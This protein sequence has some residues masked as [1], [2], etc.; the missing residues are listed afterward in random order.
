MSE[1]PVTSDVPSE[2]APRRGRKRAAFAIA[3]SIALAIAVLAIARSSHPEHRDSAPP[4]AALTVHVLTDGLPLEAAK[5]TAISNDWKHVSETAA[6]GDSEIDGAPSGPLTLTIEAEGFARATRT[7]ELHAGKS[8]VR[9]DLFLGAHLEGRVRDDTERPVPGAIVTVRPLGGGALAQEPPWLAT[10]RPDGSFSIDTLPQTR[11]TIEARGSEEFEPAVIAELELPS[12][13]PVELVLRRTAAITGGVHAA[14]GSGVAGALVTLAGSG[15]WPARTALTGPRGEFRFERVPDGIYELRAERDD[16]VSAP[17]EGIAIGPG[18]EA[19]VEIVLMAGQRLRGLVRDIANGRL[20]PDADIEVSEESLSANPKHVRSGNDGRYVISGLRPLAHR[21][22]VRANG[23]VTAQ[24]WATPNDGVFDLE[25]LRAGSISGTIQDSTGRPIALAEIEVSGRSVT[26]YTVRMLGPLNEV[27]DPS[28]PDS[29]DAAP[30][31]GNLGVT[32]AVPRLPIV[33][34]PSAVRPASGA[35]DGGFRSDARGHFQLDGLPPGE[36]V[37]AARKANFATGRSHPLQLRSGDALHDIVIELPV[38]EPLHGHV[39]DGRGAPV[40]RVRLEL[41]AANEPTRATVSGPDGA[42]RFEG[43]RGESTLVARANGAALAKL[44]VHA[45]E[46]GKRDVELVLDV[47]SDRLSGRVVDG[48]SQAIES[49]SVHLEAGGKGRDFAATAVTAPDGS[50]EFS[51]LPSPPYRVQVDHPDYVPSAVL[52]V[53]SS[54]KSLL[55]RLEAGDGLSGSVGARSSGDP[56]AGAKVSVRAG[57]VARTIR[58]S[59][60]GSFEFRHL[61]VGSFSLLIEASGFIP[62]RVQGELQD[63]GAAGLTL[64][65]VLLVRAGSCS[66]DVVDRLG[67]V[68]WNAEVTAGTPPDWD[69]A[70]RTDHA[71]HFVLGQLTPGDRVLAARHQDQA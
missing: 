69:H 67:A 46:I 13:A 71:G 29:A 3:A 50:F 16:A 10:T 22:T 59:R 55:V 19:R 14:D 5:V 6:D 42:F 27:A 53:A 23:Y 41:T 45:D 31:S 64:E 48:R 20:L 30:A 24:K 43:V 2:T 37:I 25:L 26:G 49:A 54:A 38:G 57:D 70:V 51:A 61:P 8:E 33:S 12:E 65:R 39:V 40:P 18:N 35:A 7:I 58:S 66:G 1:P 28:A 15:V 62:G 4:I 47:A 44:I 36:L 11:V 17:L 9:F 68:V 52:N 21:I 60:D 56:I 63:I 32:Q 34:L